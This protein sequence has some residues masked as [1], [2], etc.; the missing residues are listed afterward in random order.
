VLGTR[1][2]PPPPGNS[3]EIKHVHNSYTLT[4]IQCS[5][6]MIHFCIPFESSEIH[7][8]LYFL[9]C[10]TR[11]A[12]IRSDLYWSF[13]CNDAREELTGLYNGTLVNG[14]QFVSPDFSGQ[15]H[16]I[17]LNRQL[18]QYVVLPRSLNLTMNTSFTI[19]VWIFLAGYRTKT[20][21][22]DCNDYSPICIVFGATDLAL[23]MKIMDRDNNSIVQDVSLSIQN[24]T[25]IACWAYASVT[26]DLQTK[27]VSLYYNDVQLGQVPVNM[28]YPASSIES[29]TTESFIGLNAVNHAEPF[30]GLLD[31]LSISYYVKSHSEITFESTTVFNYTFQTNDKNLDSGPMRVYTR[32]QNVYQGNLSNKTTLL[33]NA[34]DSY[35]QSSGFTLLSANDY[36]FSLSFWLRLIIPHDY[37]ENGALA[38]LQFTALINELSS[39]SY[40]CLLS[41]HIYP[42]NNSI[43]FFFPKIFEII[44]V[45]NSSIMNDTRV[46]FGVTFASPDVY[47][48]YQNGQ[49]IHS[50]RKQRFSSIIPDNSRFAVTI[51]GAYLDDSLPN[52]PDNFEL[53]K[54][55]ARIPLLPYVQMYGEIDEYRMY[56]RALTDAE[57]IAL[58]YGESL[59][60]KR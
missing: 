12:S 24:Y 20:I 23:F 59:P 47:N 60:G 53:M 28:T 22:S 19:N 38:V 21:L 50:V 56:A 57:H 10:R 8:L 14:I 9:V 54:C 48:F 7:S 25:C 26:F 2:S 39:G 37:P 3:S 33:F 52:K 36:S 55:F 30:Y 40:L 1:H 16:A 13:N 49:L 35:Y 11:N 15:G 17:Q 32:S 29:R 46:H 27:L 4:V 18:R 45:K 58:A 6:G 44:Y 34:S 41:L 43:A 42:N 51:G 5:K 31:R